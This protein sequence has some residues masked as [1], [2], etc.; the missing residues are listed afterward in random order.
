[1]P[2]RKLRIEDVPKLKNLGLPEGSGYSSVSEWPRLTLSL[3]WFF[4]RSGDG[5]RHFAVSVPRDSNDDDRHREREDGM[6]LKRGPKE[7]REKS[8]HGC[9][10][11]ASE[12]ASDSL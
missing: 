1:M 12:L 6:K 7:G 11:R 9:S 5:R 2:L 10:D 3:R 4:L 8:I